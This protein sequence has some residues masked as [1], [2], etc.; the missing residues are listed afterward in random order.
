[1]Y[2]RKSQS[3]ANTFTNRE[4]KRNLIATTPHLKIAATTW[5]QSR[6]HFLTATKT[7]LSLCHTFALPLQGLGPSL[8]LLASRQARREPQNI[9][10]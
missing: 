10:I 6:R 4:A 1:V 9:A 8:P 7:P 2:F 3:P 5:Q